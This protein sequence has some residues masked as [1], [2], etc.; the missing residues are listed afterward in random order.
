MEET[1]RAESQPTVSDTHPSRWI[2]AAIRSAAWGVGFGVGAALVFLGAS[3]HENRPKR[4]DTE[5][6]RTT[7][8][9]AESLSKVPTKRKAQ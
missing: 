9:T 8:V 7:A 5:S 4:W 1:T 6:L 2:R 3:I